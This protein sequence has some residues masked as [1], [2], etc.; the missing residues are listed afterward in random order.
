MD[1][2]APIG[3]L[4]VVALA[5]L[6][7]GCRREAPPA[8]VAVTKVADITEVNTSGGSVDSVALAPDGSLV[9]IGQRNGPIRLWT[10]EDPKAPIALDGQR[11]AIVD[12]AF[13]SNGSLLAS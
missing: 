7:I 10:A 4:L 3:G 1:K 5:A 9:A 2:R 6:T 8:P 13:A 12:L 11:Q